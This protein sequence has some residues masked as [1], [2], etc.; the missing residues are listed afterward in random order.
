MR[1]ITDCLPHVDG[2]YLIV[3]RRAYE[4][5]G[6][7]D[8]R[9]NLGGPWLALDLN[10]RMMDAGYSSRNCNRM[11]DWHPTVIDDSAAKE[12]WDFIMEKH[13]IEV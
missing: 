3:A 13:R 11:I 8:D 2:P 7:F 4:E 10:L 9:M 6:L 12:N 5:I 1:M